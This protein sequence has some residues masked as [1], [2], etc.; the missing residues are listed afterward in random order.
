MSD[1]IEEFLDAKSVEDGVSINTLQAYRRDVR[2]FI[3]LLSPIKIEN[4]CDEDLEVYLKKIEAFEYSPKTIS[5]KISCIREFFKFLLSEN[6][7]RNNP[8]GKLRNPKVG[9]NLPS[10]L[11]VDEIEK[12]CDTADKEEKLSLRRMSVMIRLMYSSGLRVSEL[13]SLPETAINYDLKQIFIRGK[14][15]K[16][17]IIPVNSDTIKSVL[18]Y[19]N[20]RNEFT[21]KRK[22]PWMFPSLRSAS[23]H[24]T[25]DA[26]FKN[27]KKI[28]VKAGVSP[29]KVHPHI[30]RHSFATHLVNC[31]ADLRSIQK[32]L[33]HENVVTTEI[34][35]HITTKKLADK[36]KKYHP[37]IAKR[38][39]CL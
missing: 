26:F 21:G 35:T 5:R 6:I 3:E 29:S 30:L 37:L 12:L 14:G 16:E 22:S 18:E 13:V 8:T 33:G 15:N 17:R 9:K 2:Q 32:M 7:I 20:Y 24:M 31:E 39:G 10:F 19:T 34:Y 1:L 23:G 25:R 38:K 28:A 36:V 11:T 4:I 27:L